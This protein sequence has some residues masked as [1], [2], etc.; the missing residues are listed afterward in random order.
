[1]AR[2]SFFERVD[3]SEVAKQANLASYTPE[4]ALEGLVTGVDNLRTDVYLSPRFAEMARAHIARLIVQYGNVEDLVQEDPLV[5]V[6]QPR[7]S[8][9]VGR[10]QGPPQPI[11]AKPLDSGAEFKRGLVELQ[12]SAL[13]QAKAQGNIAIDLLARVAVLKMLRNEL[14]AQFLQVLERC[15]AKLKSYEGPR[16][17]PKGIELRDRFLKLQVAKKIVLRKAGQDLFET[18][19]EVEKESLLRMRRSLFGDVSTGTYEL[20][21]NR[22][23]FTDDG[24]DDYLNAEQYVMLGNYERDPDRFQLMLEIATGF[25]QALELT[26][27]SDAD[28]AIDGLLSVPE[29]AQELVGSGVP[30][31]GTPRGKGQRA[32]LVAWLQELERADV[33]AHVIASYEVSPLLGEYSPLINPQ[34]LKNALISRTERKRVEQLL[35]EHGKVSPEKLQAAVK[36]VEAYGGADRAKFAGR[37]LSDFMRYHRDLRRLEALNSASD[38]VNVIANEKLRELSSINSTLYEFLLP[39]E[40][41]PAE[42]KVIDHI[43]LKA[44][45]RDSTML[46]RTLYERG[47]NPASYF[48][49]NFYEP[50]NKLL[51]KYGASKVFIEG[52][53]VILAMF[54]REGEQNFG[55]ARTCMLA[56]EMIDVVRGY[57]EQSQKSGLPVLE[58]GL[59]I[60]YQDSPPMYL[61]DGSS[62]I[63]ISKAL[64]E[65][66]RLS[67]C[68]KG[69]RKYLANAGS[70]FNV[71]SFQTVDDA[72]TAGI[73]EEFLLRYNIGGIHINAAAFTKLQQEISLETRDVLLPM[74]WGQ[75]RVRLYSGLVPLGSGVFHPIVV[76]EARVAHIDAR[77]FA[78]KDWTDR[79]YYEVCANTAVYD[80]VRAA[81]RSGSTS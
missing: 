55:V 47:L 74:L 24:R 75:E 34:Q 68:S 49:L 14:A 3:I 35:D 1:M 36:R 19:R 32:L 40:Q 48:S 57:N 45:I 7:V 20:F 11:P 66:D 6:P 72:D 18:L 81:A 60:C 52:D 46:T 71:F 42:D 21:L 26:N 51:P 63:M 78:V 13:N 67:S 59:G 29:N 50:I 43:I 80:L 23:L 30:E 2:F 65:S 4:I 53:A 70:L 39:E 69:A 54:E 33:I 28:S 31:D 38:S 17:S 22:L 61:M 73:P 12:L 58:L 16:T 5:R 64:N 27:G 10:A 25:L 77:D 56:R 79:K 44:D 9:F 41:K 76:R 62:R 37:F 8:N 15:R